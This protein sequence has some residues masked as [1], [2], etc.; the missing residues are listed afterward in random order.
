MFCSALTPFVSQEN[1]EKFCQFSCGIRGEAAEVLRP[2]PALQPP[3]HRQLCNGFHASFRSTRA[4]N[5]CLCPKGGTA[6]TAQLLGVHVAGRGGGRGR[7]G[8]REK[9]EREKDNFN[10]KDRGRLQ[11]GFLQA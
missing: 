5:N 1:E 11:F 4:R 7:G 2:A 10:V 6:L 9:K 3:R 8:S